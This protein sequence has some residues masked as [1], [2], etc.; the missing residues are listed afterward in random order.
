MAEGNCST[1]MAVLLD[2]RTD[3]AQTVQEVLTE[4]GCIIRSRI[5]LHQITECTEECLIILHLCGS[6]QEIEKLEKDLDVIHRV[7]VK[8]MKIAFDE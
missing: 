5:G 3:S 8:K 6:D 2:K 7:K 1:I 4:H